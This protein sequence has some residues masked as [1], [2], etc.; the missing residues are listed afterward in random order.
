MCGSVRVCVRVCACVS[1]C[2][3]TFTCS[4]VCVCVRTEYVH[5]SREFLTKT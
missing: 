3:Q 2:A 4:W 1:A 5:V